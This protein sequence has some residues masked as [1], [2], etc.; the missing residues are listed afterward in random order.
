MADLPADLQE[1]R[2]TESERPIRQWPFVAHEIEYAYG[3]GDAAT[4]LANFGA[5]GPLPI[6]TVG[7]VIK[8]HGVYVKV[9]DVVVGYDADADGAPSVIA[10]VRVD[11]AGLF[12]APGS[13][14]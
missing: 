13:G 11:S 3:E 1:I 14:T 6:P 12:P 7:Q 8:L 10:A 2:D 9:L 4:V 5:D